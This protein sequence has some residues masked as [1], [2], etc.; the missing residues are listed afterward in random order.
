MDPALSLVFCLS[1]FQ[2]NLKVEADN[3]ERFS[4][5]FADVP[6]VKFPRPLRPYV[7]PMVGPREIVYEA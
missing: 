4:E 3:L 2:I 7:T 1:N 6:F 5:N